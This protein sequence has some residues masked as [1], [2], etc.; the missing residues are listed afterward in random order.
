MAS[1]KINEAIE[2]TRKSIEDSIDDNIIALHVKQNGLEPEVD[3]EEPRLICR[4]M[5]F[6]TIEVYMYRT[7]PLQ[8]R[9]LEKKPL[10]VP[11]LVMNHIGY[12][13]LKFHDRAPKQVTPVP[14]TENNLDQAPD[15]HQ[16]EGDDEEDEELLDAWN[17]IRK[18][19]HVVRS[20]TSKPQYREGVKVETAPTPTA[21]VSSA[22]DRTSAEIERGRSRS[23][24]GR[25]SESEVAKAAAAAAVPSRKGMSSG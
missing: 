11:S 2:K 5:V 25:Q 22:S 17:T 12:E 3:P 6:D 4:K 14:S 24:S 7:L 19:S 21:S 15:N 18:H 1:E 10:V 9:H 20:T 8:L 16:V 13:G 23:G